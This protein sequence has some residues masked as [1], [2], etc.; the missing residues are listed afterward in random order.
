MLNLVIEEIQSADD[1]GGHLGYTWVR[2]AKG[3]YMI[4]RSYGHV[5][6]IA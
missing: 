3:M 1:C 4:I 5:V 2:H 6:A